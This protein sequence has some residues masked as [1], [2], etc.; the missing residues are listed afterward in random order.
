MKDKSS[1]VAYGYKFAVVASIALHLCFVTIVEAA[2]WLGKVVNPHLQDQ[3]ITLRAIRRES[4]ARSRQR[5]QA[6]KID[7]GTPS[8]ND[9]LKRGASQNSLKTSEINRSKLQKGSLPRQNSNSLDASFRNFRS[10]QGH[11]DKRIQKVNRN[12]T[13][14]IT[15]ESK[16]TPVESVVSHVSD[17][18]KVP[19][20]VRKNLLPA[21]LKQM[22]SKI[23]QNWSQVIEPFRFESGIATV[24]Y[25]IASDGTIEDLQVLS[26]RGGEMFH[27]ACLLSVRNASPF[28]RLPF[29][30]E[31]SEEKQYLTVALTFYLRTA[32]QGTLIS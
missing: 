11:L 32:D 23:A 30:F 28:G 19:I 24:Q 13:S 14:L 7:P 9:N 2:V 22:R 26:A 5:L 4:A 15:Q 12:L 31:K 21:Y 1:V 10:V 6:E 29:E 27:S 16:L 18:E 8:A 3:L 25:R 20:E 17:L